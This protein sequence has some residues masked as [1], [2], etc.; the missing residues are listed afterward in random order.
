[1]ANIYFVTQNVGFVVGAGGTILKTTN[2]GVSWEIKSSGTNLGLT[3]V[4]FPSLNVGYAVGG[5]I[6]WEVSYSIVK[7]SIDSGQTWTEVLFDSI[8]PFSSVAFTDNLAGYVAGDSGR[9]FKTTDGGNSWTPLNIGSQADIAD[10][11]FTDSV[12]GFVVGNNST[13]LK[14]ADAG[15]SW[16]DVSYCFPPNSI[17][18]SISFPT[19]EVGYALGID[20]G[21]SLVA[22]TTD[23][24]ETWSVLLDNLWTMSELCFTSPDTGYISGGYQDVRTTDGGTSWETVISG[25]WGSKITF[26]DAFTGY[27]VDGDAFYSPQNPMIMKTIDFGDTWFPLVDAVTYAMLCHIE[28]PERNIGFT[29]GDNLFNG[30]VLKTLDGKTWEIVLNTFDTALVESSFLNKDNGYVCGFLLEGNEH[31][32][33]IYRT[34]NGG[35]SWLKSTLNWPF[36][37]TSIS[38]INDS[39][40]FIVGGSSTMAEVDPAV[41]KTLD[42][43]NTWDSVFYD[44]IGLYLS[45]NFTSTDTGFL[46]HRINNSAVA[47]TNVY[48]TVNQGNSWELSFTKDGYLPISLFFLDNNYGYLLADNGEKIH[49]TTNGGFTWDTVYCP[50]LKATSLFFIDQLNGYTVSSQGEISKTEDA[51]ETWISLESPTCNYLSDL[52]FFGIDTG[53]VVGSLGTIL[54]TADGGYPVNNREIFPDK[55]IHSFNYPNP[56]SNTTTIT[57]NLSSISD[58]SIEIYRINGEI[59]KSTYMMRQPAGK[60]EVLFDASNLPSGIYLY[61]IKLKDDIETKK[62][63]VIH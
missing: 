44:T 22:K 63:V 45:V 24:G 46:L 39:V 36:R 28:F 25:A 13:L 43:G 60:F 33:F 8:G 31:K 54:Y 15:L 21:S 11:V 61:R 27:F 35:G 62:M 12:T 29:V 48:K 16:K 20:Q 53:Y 37:P 52:F 42:Y 34:F 38:F 59:L 51:G 18:I 4:F 41:F 1:M 19:P 26:T 30:Q 55:K 17:I 49:R 50:T 5:S 23:G 57:C 2:A 56:F 32:G 7:K 47:R 58:I 14:T 40:G 6:T 9:V 10:I 3:N